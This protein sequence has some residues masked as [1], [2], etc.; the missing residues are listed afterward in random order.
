MN[1]IF[2]INYPNEIGYERANALFRDQAKKN[3]FYGAEAQILF[4]GVHY[5]KPEGDFRIT[6]HSNTISMQANIDNQFIEK[7][8]ELIES[9]LYPCKKLVTAVF[10]KVPYKIFGTGLSRTGTT[11]L[12]EALKALGIFS[13]HHAPFLFPAIK[14]NVKAL[15]SILEYDAF[16]DTPFSYLFKELDIAYPGSKFIHTE[17]DATSWINSF[18]WL[19]GNSSTP[20]SRWFYGTENGNTDKYVE[21]YVAHQAEVKEYFQDRPQDFLILN[22]G[23]GNGWQ[24]LCDFLDKPIPAEAYPTLHTREGDGSVLAKKEQKLE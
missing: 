1:T 15:D 9:V 20:M 5:F 16:I 23:E 6:I 17:R 11:S 10:S 13:T 4:N 7:K 19:L 22:L 18:K 2:N 3:V 8:D 14:D 21:R 24:K 12:H